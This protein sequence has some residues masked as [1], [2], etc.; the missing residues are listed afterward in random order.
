MGRL[1]A[2]RAFTLIELLV[3]MAIIAI[4]IG[5]LLPAVQKVRESANRTA[6]ANNMRQIGLAVIGYTTQLGILPTGGQPA[7]AITY[8]R[9][10]PAAGANS[11]PQTGKDQYWGWAYQMLPFLDQENLW[12]SPNSDAG[13]AIVLGAVVPVFSCPTRRPPFVH[14][15]TDWPASPVNKQ[16]HFLSDYAGNWGMRAYFLA[17]SSFNG[18]IAS[19]TNAIK[20]SSVKAGLAQTLLIGEK[21]V[22]TAP[23][24]PDGAETAHDEVSAFYSMQTDNCRYGDFSPMRDGPTK[25][26]DTWAFRTGGPGDIRF[27]P[28][29]SAHPAAMNAVFGDGSSRTIRYNVPDNLFQKVCNRDN[30]SPYNPDDL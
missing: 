11:S 5:L 3:V 13:D 21:Y 1:S 18:L 2:R 7:V 9:F 16:K 10:A 22:T 20:P 30:Q 12:R 28:F 6:C 29:G 4:L 24:F 15:N 27:A 26:K 25:A 23:D 17:N 8:S 19:R 14:V